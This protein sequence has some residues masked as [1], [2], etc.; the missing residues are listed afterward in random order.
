MAYVRQTIGKQKHEEMSA[1]NPA[2][3]A[4]L[5]Q[6]RKP[7]TASADADLVA[8]ARGGDRFAFG[9]LYQRH[10][11]MVH[12]VLLARVAPSVADDL[13]QDVFV[14]AMTQLKSLRDVNT[15]GGWLA[16]I[17][18]NRAHDHFRRSHETQPLEDEEHE[19]ID[20]AVP[21]TISAES[22]AHTALAALQ[23]L[24][25]TY[26]ETL[27]MRL[28]EGMTGPEIAERTGLTPD[29]VRVNLHRGMKLLRQQLERRRR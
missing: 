18:R 11:R 22:E 26:R 7:E 5:R 28:V 3:T 8:A 20:V 27:A 1:W 12:A 23:S 17:A 16:A 25:E 13:V 29:S 24:P 21:E 19:P 15:F 14:R 2:V 9:Q 10:H 4:A 6:V